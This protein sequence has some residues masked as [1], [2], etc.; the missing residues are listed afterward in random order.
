MH[1]I[2][3]IDLFSPFSMRSLLFLRSRYDYKDSMRSSLF[4]AILPVL[5]ES[6]ITYKPLPTAIAYNS[7][8]ACDCLQTSFYRAVAYQVLFQNAIA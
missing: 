6:A 3:A 7:L 2:R 5:Y 1:K 8:L 4:F